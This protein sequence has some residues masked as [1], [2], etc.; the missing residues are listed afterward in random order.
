MSRTILEGAVIREFTLKIFSGDG[1]MIAI[2]RFAP[3]LVSFFNSKVQLISNVIHLLFQMKFG[4]PGALA[5]THK[6]F[7]DGAYKNGSQA[8]S[9]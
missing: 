6:R 1:S 9:V 3:L 4:R 5:E 8:P 7:C 2:V